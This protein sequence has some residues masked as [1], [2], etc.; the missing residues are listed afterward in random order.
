MW[1]VSVA[2]ISCIFIFALSAFLIESMEEEIKP[3]DV[4]VEAVLKI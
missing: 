4:H 1:K 3:D 2:L